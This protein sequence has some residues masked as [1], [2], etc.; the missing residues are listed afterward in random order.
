MGWHGRLDQAD[1]GG[2]SGARIR[3]RKHRRKRLWLMG[4]ISCAQFVSDVVRALV[5]PKCHSA[6][7][8]AEVDAT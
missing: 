6:L 3:S 5:S 1:G 4:C 7:E 8:M 2:A